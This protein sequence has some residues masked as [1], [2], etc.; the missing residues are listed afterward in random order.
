L[1]FV[2]TYIGVSI[3]NL[4]KIMMRSHGA[5]VKVCT[6][7]D[8]DYDKCEKSA[9]V[10]KAIIITSVVISILIKTCA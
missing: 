5:F 8:E 4:V 2:G 3:Y 6:D 10:H 9:N 7:L 1:Y